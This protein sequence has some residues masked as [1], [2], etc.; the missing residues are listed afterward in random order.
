M[1][2]HVR[3]TARAEDDLD[4]ILT[5]LLQRQA[6]ERG[7]RWFDGLIGK[8]RT[9]SEFPGRCPLAR[10]AS[11]VSFDVRQLL[12]GR[13]PYMYRVLF[14]IDDGIVYILRVRGPRQ[15]DVSLHGP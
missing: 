5:W 7:L 3:Y 14:T 13:K 15:E 6:G 12:Y 8:V 9:L 4:G 11:S 10:E 1:A 2:F